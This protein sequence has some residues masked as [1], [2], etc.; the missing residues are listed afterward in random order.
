[1]TYYELFRVVIRVPLLVVEGVS[2]SDFKFLSYSKNFLDKNATVKTLPQE[3][4][5]V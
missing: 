5:F 3:R 4:P 1:M 2:E